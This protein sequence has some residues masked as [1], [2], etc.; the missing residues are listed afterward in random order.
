M[1]MLAGGALGW[2]VVIEFQAVLAGSVIALWALRRIVRLGPEHR[3][4]P[5]AA[6]LAGGM[7][8]GAPLI[9]YNLLAFGVPIKFGYSGVVGFEGMQQGLFGLTYPKLPVLYELVF[10]LRRGL[11]WVAPVLLLAPPGIARMIREAAT[12]DAGIMAAATITVVLLVNAAYV[13]WDG[14]FS[15]GPRHSVPALPLLALGLAPLWVSLEMPRARMAMLGLLALSVAINLIIAATEIT[16]PDTERFPLW[17]PILS[18][19]VP[20]GWFR[21]LPGQFWGWS[22]W[23]GVA[24]YLILAG[25]IG[26]ALMIAVQAPRQAIE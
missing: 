13:Y 9:G 23:A 21:D 2:A 22:P 6:A 11:I 1:A 19:N 10:G 24:L 26:A 15:T 7:I 16:A 12:R 4:A 5:I 25:M 8:A 18:V 3:I 17:S 14:G 20:N